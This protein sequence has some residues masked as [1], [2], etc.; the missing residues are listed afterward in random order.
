MQGYKI[1]A[2]PTLVKARTAR[3]AHPL[4]PTNAARTLNGHAFL[5]LY[6]YARPHSTYGLLW[7]VDTTFSALITYEYRAYTNAYKLMHTLS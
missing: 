4:K 3:V 7:S 2:A 1:D 6:E 5:F